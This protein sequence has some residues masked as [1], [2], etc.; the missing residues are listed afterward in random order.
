MHESNTADVNWVDFLSGSVI[1]ID[2]FQLVL[3]NDPSGSRRDCR[4]VVLDWS[5]INSVRGKRVEGVINGRYH[6]HH[7]DSH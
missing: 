5:G 1:F 7:C 6:Q 3:G 4:S 2:V